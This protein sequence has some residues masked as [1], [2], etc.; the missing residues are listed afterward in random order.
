MMDIA[1]SCAFPN[2]WQTVMGLDFCKQQNPRPAWEAM[3]VRQQ[4]HNLHVLNSTDLDQMLDLSCHQ[5]H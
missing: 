5:A 4:M 1:I 3:P 2:N